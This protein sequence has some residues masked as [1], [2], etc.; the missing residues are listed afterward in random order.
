MLL[1]RSYN[2]YHY[3]CNCITAKEKQITKRKIYFTLPYILS[4]V[5]LLA[6]QEACICCMGIC[7]P[8]AAPGGAS[9]VEVLAGLVEVFLAFLVAVAAAVVADMGSC[10]P[11]PVHNNNQ[12]C[13]PVV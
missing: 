1:T 12:P 5:Q 2:N 4:W 6:C 3:H 13:N 11:W 10:S 8:M 7:C 9:D